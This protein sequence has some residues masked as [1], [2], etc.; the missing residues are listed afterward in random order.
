MIQN[1]K[2]LFVGFMKPCIREYGGK[3]CGTLDLF[4]QMWVALK[5]AFWGLGEHFINLLLGCL[6]GLLGE[7]HCLDV[8]QHTT[9]GD[10]HTS[11]QFVELLVVADSQLKVTGDDTGL[12]VVTGSVAGQLQ[13]FSS[14]ILEHSSQVDRCTGSNA[15]SIVAFAQESVDTTHGEL[16]TSTRRPGLCLCSGLASGFSSSAHFC[17]VVSL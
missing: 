2:R 6:L 3:S 10:G 1:K 9:L 12:L 5:R 15:L 13:D 7:K 17:L 8:G 4:R 11:E 14:Q 16:E